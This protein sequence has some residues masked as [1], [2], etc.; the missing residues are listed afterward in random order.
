M[1]DYEAITLLN[2]LKEEEAQRELERQEKLRDKK[3]GKN[4]KKAP[5]EEPINLD[6]KTTKDVNVTIFNESNRTIGMV[7][8]HMQLEKKEGHGIIRNIYHVEKKMGVYNYD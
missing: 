5:K 6:I 7:L 8:Y 3:G 4:S 2:R 1:P